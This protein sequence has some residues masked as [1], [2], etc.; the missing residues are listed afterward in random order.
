[1]SELKRAYFYLSER[2]RDNAINFAGE[3]GFS[4]SEFMRDAL[5]EKINRELLVGQVMKV[6]E[7]LSEL[8]LEM[9]TEVARTRKDLMDDNQRGIELVRQDIA[10]S[11]KKNEEMTKTFV[12]QLAGIEPRAE[13]PSKPSKHNEDSPMRIPG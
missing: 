5:A 7:E 13:K 10:K 6:R 3:A 4:F 8:V 1:M 2:E 12:M 11:M 9:R